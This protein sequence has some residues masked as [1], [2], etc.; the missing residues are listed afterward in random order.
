MLDSLRIDWQKEDD[1]EVPSDL[2]S[3]LSDSDED[4]ELDDEEGVERMKKMAKEVDDDDME[5]L[6]PREARERRDKRGKYQ[7]FRLLTSP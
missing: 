4:Y 6:P 2:D 1:C 3:E 7:L 5:W